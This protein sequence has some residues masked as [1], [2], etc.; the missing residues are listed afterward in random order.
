MS[1]YYPDIL[2]NLRNA[3]RER[4]CER[5]RACK[6]LWTETQRDTPWP[7]WRLT[8]TDDF[9]NCLQLNCN[10]IPFSK[11]ANSYISNFRILWCHLTKLLRHLTREPNYLP[12]FSFPHSNL[13]QDLNLFCLY[14]V[15]LCR[16][17]WSHILVAGERTWTFQID[18]H[19]RSTIFANL[20]ANWK[21]W[22]PTKEDNEIIKNIIN[23]HSN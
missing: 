4:V 13:W 8:P 21:S 7:E 2:F 14:L 6:G 16:D 17:D 1:L 23:H 15:L 3:E 18:W 11:F 9:S 22:G 5:E 12:C 10:L 19:L 20:T